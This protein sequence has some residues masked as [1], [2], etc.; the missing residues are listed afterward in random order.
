MIRLYGIF[1]SMTLCSRW[2]E[3]QLHELARGIID[4]HQQG[5]G[6]GAILETAVLA[7]V[8]LH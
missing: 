8:D 2:H 4:E 7:A 6:L 5:A 1:R 3:A